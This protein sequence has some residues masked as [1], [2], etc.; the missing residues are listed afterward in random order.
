MLHVDETV[1]S[2]LATLN[3]QRCRMVLLECMELQHISQ[4]KKSN[5][6]AQSPIRIYHFFTG[7]LCRISNLL[8]HSENMAYYFILSYMYNFSSDFIWQK[9]YISW[10]LT[11]ILYNL[12][13]WHVLGMTILKE[14][15]TS[16]K[17]NISE[18]QYGV[19]SVFRERSGC[20]LLRKQRLEQCRDRTY[21]GCIAPTALERQT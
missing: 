4:V 15:Y 2:N 6:K 14:H 21:L 1:D 9:S 8:L 13:E 3:S 7:C 18:Y 16:E 11:V 19:S 17:I 12:A 20:I 10:P 5:N